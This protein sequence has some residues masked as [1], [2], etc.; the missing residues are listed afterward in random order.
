MEEKEI[1]LLELWYLF[2]NNFFKYLFFAILVGGLTFLVNNY[3]LVPKY[4][5]GASIIINNSKTGGNDIDINEVKL[6]QELVN[7]YTEIVKTRG[8]ADIVIENLGLDMEYKE[9]TEKVSVS[10]KNG[11]E[12]FEVK[13]VDTLAARATDIANETAKVFQQSVKEI[14]KIDN[15][16]IL[17]KAVIPEDPISPNIIRNTILGA[18]VGFILGIFLSFVRMLTDNTIKD[19]DD[20]INTFEI[21]VLGIIPDRGRKKEKR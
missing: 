7:T 14:M 17:D 12:I 18:L 5:A 1:D 15:V 13:V 20:F 6:N 8:I 16:Q 3:L 19:A 10:S 11:T 21:P 4:E 2:K 9:F